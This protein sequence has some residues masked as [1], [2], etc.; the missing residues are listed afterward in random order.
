MQYT[1]TSLKYSAA[2]HGRFS[3]FWDGSHTHSKKLLVLKNTAQKSKTENRQK[4]ITKKIKHAFCSNTSHITSEIHVNI[5]MTNNLSCGPSGNQ[6][7]KA[8]STTILSSMRKVS[9]SCQ[10]YQHLY[11]IYQK[12]IIYV[13]LTHWLRG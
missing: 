12:H 8:C 2:M 11:I 4:I 9:T 13:S 3:M 6:F 5:F 1:A 10:K 7:K